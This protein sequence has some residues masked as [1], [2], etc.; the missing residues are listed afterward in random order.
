MR[1]N[2]GESYVVAVQVRIALLDPN[3][4]AHGDHDQRHLRLRHRSPAQGGEL[5]ALRAV[6]EAANRRLIE[7]EL[8][9]ESCAPDADTL[10]RVVLPSETDGLPAPALRFGDPRVV[11]LL[12]ALVCFCNGVAGFTNAT[13]RPLV[14]GMLG[15]PY[16]SRQLTYDLRR[17]RRKDFI[18]RIAGTHTYRLTSQGRRLAMFL[19][20]LYA[21][22]ITRSP[23]S[24][25]RSVTTSPPAVH[26]PGPGAPSR[27]PS[28]KRW[29]A[30]GS[31]PES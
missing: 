31:R 16:S 25:P 3:G 14:E 29:P 2:T 24:I 18:E 19:T 22:L 6:G 11:S 21:R 27:R 12:A 9:S 7:L 13:L 1:K 10:A 4:P 30:Q 5:R 26:L 17:L 8:S 23:I 20:K 15:A 28:T